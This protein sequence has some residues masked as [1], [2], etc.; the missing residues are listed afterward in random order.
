MSYRNALSIIIVAVVTTALT[1]CGAP[2]GNDADTGDQS[3]FQAEPDARFA[4][5]MRDVRFDVSEIE[6]PAG[7]LIAITF[8]NRGDIEHDFSITEFAGTFA[9]RTASAAHG[10]STSRAVHM[11]LRPGDTGEI[12]LRVPDTGGVEFFCDVAG[13]RRAG[14]SGTI[15]FR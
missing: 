5:D 11:A 7:A 13:H 3:L 10:R 14:M 6:A 4:I 8:T 15:A 2:S 1:A 9:Y 12:R